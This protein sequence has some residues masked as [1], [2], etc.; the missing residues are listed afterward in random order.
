LYTLHGFV[1]I[2]KYGLGN[3]NLLAEV[4]TRLGTIKS[5]YVLWSPEDLLKVSE[6]NIDGA[7]N[8]DDPLAF[9]AAPLPNLKLF[10]RV[11]A[12]DVETLWLWLLLVQNLF[13]DDCFDA[14]NTVRQ[15]IP[16]TEGLAFKA[17]ASGRLT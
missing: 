8:V 9:F 5:V 1:L 6:Q 4:K 11:G 7:G 13:R 17:L 2:L 14:T 10:Y 12:D 16:K 15:D 3:L